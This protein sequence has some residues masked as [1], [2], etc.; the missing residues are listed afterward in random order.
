MDKVV[1]FWI[2]QKNIFVLIPPKKSNDNDNDLCRMLPSRIQPQTPQAPQARACG[3]M[4]TMIKYH[5]HHQHL[6]HHQHHQQLKD[7]QHQQE[8]HTVT[9]CDKLTSSYLFQSM[10]VS[11]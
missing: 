10:T 6:Q 11:D 2:L 8:N 1:R 3:A 5:M 7:S 4:I 9:S